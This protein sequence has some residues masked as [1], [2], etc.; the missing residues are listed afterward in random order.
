M[1]TPQI[2]PEWK[3]YRKLHEDISGVLSKAGF[4]VVTDPVDAVRALAA[5]RDRILGLLDAANDRLR[6]ERAVMGPDVSPVAA[7]LKRKLQAAHRELE[8]RRRRDEEL[9][10]HMPV[11]AARIQSLAADAALDLSGA[12]DPGEQ[13]DQDRTIDWTGID[14]GHP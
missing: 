14:G 8:R 5:D 2:P 4:R 10:A 1:T 11:I 6:C 3:A 13:W 7:E 12:K 9:A